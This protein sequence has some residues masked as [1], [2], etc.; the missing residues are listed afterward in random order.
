MSIAKKKWE[1]SLTPRFD[2]AKVIEEL[3]IEF[4]DKR[5]EQTDWRT[6]RNDLIRVRDKIWMRNE[7]HLSFTLARYVNGAKTYK[8]ITGRG[9]VYL[10]GRDQASQLWL[11]RLTPFH[12]TASIEACERWLF[13]ISKSDTIVA[14]A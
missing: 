9:Q 7:V 11:H 8:L 12:V 2:S 3:G 1:D 5:P 6:W 13:N 14:E 4:T 10:I